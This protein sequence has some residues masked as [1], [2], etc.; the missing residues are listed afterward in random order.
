MPTRLGID[1]T[2]EAGLQ[3]E[4]C[5]CRGERLPTEPHHDH[6]IDAAHEHLKSLL[7]R[8]FNSWTNI[9]GKSF[10]AQLT[11]ACEPCGEQV[12]RFETTWV[13]NECNPVDGHGKPAR[14]IARPDETLVRFYS[15]LP[16]QLAECRTYEFWQEAYRL[17][18]PGL[19][20]RVREA[21]R[22]AALAANNWI[23]I[24]K[25]LLD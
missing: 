10:Y 22:L 1:L 9:R 13:C 8:E 6:V 12:V 4:I 3:P 2:K 18:R 23:V 11:R 14:R 21:R 17:D 7:G 20:R 5:Q 15:M 25:S 16:A 19:E 24:E